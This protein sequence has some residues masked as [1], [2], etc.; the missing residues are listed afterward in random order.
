VK[1]HFDWQPPLILTRHKKLIVTANDLKRIEN[2]PGVYYFARSQGAN[3]EPFYIGETLTLRTRLKQH[4]ETAKIAD[5]LR[6]MNVAGAPAISNGPRS[7]HFAYFKPQKGPLKVKKALTVAQEFMIREAIAMNL[8]LLNVKLTII[9]THSLTFSGQ[10]VRRS[11][12]KKEN[13]VAL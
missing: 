4:L 12:F 2:V 11:I 7:F 6:G 9:K 8:P 1:L 13:S 5:I 3:S 10:S